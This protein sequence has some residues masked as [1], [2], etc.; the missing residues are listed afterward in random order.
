MG[1]HPTAMKAL[2]SGW[3]LREPDE[4]AILSAKDI[5]GDPYGRHCIE[6]TQKHKII[7]IKMFFNMSLQD[8]RFSLTFPKFGDTS[9]W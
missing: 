9:V 5:G 3:I 1:I 7:L 4:R 8:V 2:T 6:R